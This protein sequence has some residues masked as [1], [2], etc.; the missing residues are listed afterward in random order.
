[1][2]QIHG[3]GFVMLDHASVL[4]RADFWFLQ[5]RSGVFVNKGR[6]DLIRQMRRRKFK[7]NRK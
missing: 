5:N 2:R 4:E 6:D 7:E 3:P 1:M